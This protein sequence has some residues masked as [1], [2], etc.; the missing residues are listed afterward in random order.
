M[1]HVPQS[2]MT[3]LADAI[4]EEAYQA[5]LARL[6]GYILYVPVKIGQHHPIAQTIGLEASAKLSQE[7]AG[8]SL[9]LPVTARRRAVIEAMLEEGKGAVQIARTVYCSPRYVWKVKAEMDG[10]SE[11]QQL[12]LL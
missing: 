12:G 8:L 9:N 7:F 2:R 3:E 11:P 10:S 1:R 4:G 6:G 5:L